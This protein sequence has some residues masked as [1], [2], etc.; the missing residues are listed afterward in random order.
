MYNEC[1]YANLTMKVARALKSEKRSKNY[2]AGASGRSTQTGSGEAEQSE[3]AALGRL[4][5]DQ[6]FFC[7]VIRPSW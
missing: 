6:L 4:P 1:Y 3:R 7:Y 5:R 2:E